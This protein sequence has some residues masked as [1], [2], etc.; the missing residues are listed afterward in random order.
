MH[1]DSLSLNPQSI[2]W[3]KRILRKLTM[4][5]CSDLLTQILRQDSVSASN[6]LVRESIFK[7]FPDELQFYS[8]LLEQEEE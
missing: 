6:R 7:R 1:V 2:P 8:S 4:E 5:E 3:I